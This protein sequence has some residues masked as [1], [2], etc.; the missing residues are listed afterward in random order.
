MCSSLLGTDNFLITFKRRAI[1]YT[2]L[3]IRL[4]TNNGRIKEEEAQNSILR[5]RERKQQDATNLMFIVKLLTQHVSGIIMPII[6]RT[7]FCTTAYGFLH[8]NI[9]LQCRT[10]YAVVHGLAVLMMGLMMPETCGDKGL[11]INIRLD[12]SCWFLSLHPTSMMHG[13]KN[14]K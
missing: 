3:V 5:W 8:C 7:R 6:R 1:F 4:I 12:A 13:Y 9:L 10:P 2:G 14:L 11:I